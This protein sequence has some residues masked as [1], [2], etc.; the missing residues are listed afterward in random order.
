MENKT[1]RTQVNLNKIYRDFFLTLRSSWFKKHK[2]SDLLEFCF[3]L[4]DCL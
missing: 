3:R 2:K 1:E 4:T